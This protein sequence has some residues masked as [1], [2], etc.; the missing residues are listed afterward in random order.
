VHSRRLLAEHVGQDTTLELLEDGRTVTV[1]DGCVGCCCLSDTGHSHLWARLSDQLL[2]RARPSTIAGIGRMSRSKA[3]VCTQ[4]S[5]AYIGS[6][7]SQ[8]MASPLW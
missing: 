1:H 8:R 5:G 2:E 6:E 7:H 3:A 4:K